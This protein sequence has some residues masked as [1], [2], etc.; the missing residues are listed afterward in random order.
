MTDKELKIILEKRFK[1]N[2]NRHMGIKWN[3]IL[4]KL[5]KE[6]LQSL[7]YMEETAGEPD[8]IIYN[9]ENGNYLY[10]D[11]SKESPIHRRNL[12]YDNEVLIKRKR[13]KPISSAIVEAEKN[14]IKL[15]T[16]EE[17]KYLQKLGDFDLKSSSW[18]LTEKETRLLGG[19]IF[20]DKRYN[21]TFIYHNSAESYYSNR[22]FRGKLKI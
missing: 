18:L 22:G 3:D 20:G 10:C 12:C 6:A 15:L 7:R 8:V 4:K 16:E 1:E 5:N 11:C 2:M 19:T 14:N 21:R 13:N 17:Y 9:V